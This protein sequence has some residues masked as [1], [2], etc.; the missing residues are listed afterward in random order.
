[1]NYKWLFICPLRGFDFPV[2]NI[3]E[4]IKKF[5]TDQRA[6]LFMSKEEGQG[7]TFFLSR[8]HRYPLF[9]F[10]IL[11]LPF[12]FSS[13]A[14]FDSFFLSSLPKFVFSSTVQTLVWRVLLS[15]LLPERRE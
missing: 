6:R 7:L 3:G 1:M 4:L 10:L 2:D 5:L 9:F 15:S 12:A 11:F 14:F 8:R 13:R